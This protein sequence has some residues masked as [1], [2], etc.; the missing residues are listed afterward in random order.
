M[1]ISEAQQRVHNTRTVSLLRF[2]DIKFIGL[3]RIAGIPMTKGNIANAAGQ[4]S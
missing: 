1:K 2:A 3:C 4:V